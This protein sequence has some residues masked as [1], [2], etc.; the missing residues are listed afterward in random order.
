MSR[1]HRTSYSSIGFP[2]W[3]RAVKALIIAC[4][5]TYIVQ[6]IAGQGF[7]NQFGLLPA[8][9][10]HRGYVW[11]LVSYIFLHDPRSLLHIILNM[12]GLW[13]FGSELE[14]VWGTRQFTKFFFICGIGAGVLMV[15]LF[16]VGVDFPVPTIGASGSIYGVLLAYGIL[17]PDRI[18][19]WLIFPIPARYFVIIMGAIAFYSSLQASTGVAHIA[20]LGGMACGYVY[21]KTRGMV[22]RS[23]P[24]VSVGFR[25]WYDRW[26]RN[27][28]RKKFDVYYNRRHPESDDDKWRRWKN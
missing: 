6:L 12:L 17:F 4:G 22:R 25:A 18:I 3:T 7:T 20:H 10:V 2:R 16:L 5:I 28:L 11:Q 26:K 27:R 1:Y 23:G 8:D 24:G 15:L 9:V 21:L 19:Y 14:M 13:M